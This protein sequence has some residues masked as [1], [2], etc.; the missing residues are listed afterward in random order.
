MT[1]ILG[2]NGFSGVGHDAAAALLVDG[3]VV[4]AV[5]EE[6][7]TR[8]KRAPG[9]PP[10]QAISETL[11]IAGISAAD[12][13]VVTYPWMPHAMGVA[14]ADVEAAIRSWFAE[15]RAST[16]IRFV[17][18]HLAHA[19]SGMAFAPGGIRGRRVGMLVIDGSGEATGGACYTYDGSNDATTLKWRLPQS[20]SLGVYY[21]AASFYLGF[22]WGDEGK[23]MGMAAYG[24][25]LGLQV[26]PLP[27]HRFDQPLPDWV[28]HDKSPREAHSQCRWQFIEEFRRLHG[29]QL[30]FNQRADIALAA[31]NIVGRRIAEYVTE[32]LDD[33]DVLVISGGV[34]L[35][36]AINAQTAAQC[37]AKGVEFVVPPPA[38]DTGV[39][40]GSAVAV[41]STLDGNQN[42]QSVTPITDPFL[43]RMFE[44]DAIMKDLR[45][46]GAV[47]ET[48]SMEALA[49]KLLEG[50]AICGWF[51][52]RS[53]IGP[54]ALGKR[55]I[56]ARTDS[57]SLR[58]RVNLLKGRESWRPLAPSVTTAEFAR[59]F[60]GSTPSAYMLINATITPGAT[61]RLCG[62]VHVD[63]T[64]RPQV[65]DTAGAYHNLLKRVGVLSGTEAV[66]CTSF[67]RAGEPMVYTP[68][69][70]LKSAR[71]MGL[72]LLAGDGWLVRL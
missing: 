32:L 37:H 40:L 5:E 45:N 47:V 56:I 8:V 12:I 51:E 30:S 14:Q 33:I 48:T 13:D 61:R 39:A 16:E 38:S 59:S 34:A 53:E 23:T 36:C 69:D 22:R 18:H 66:I 64:S 24:R 44:P 6:R 29:D 3:V 9:M 25:D 49:T 41:A 10:T 20:S 35:N 31:Q 50:S 28:E 71:A 55:S 43:G 11:H 46:Q 52:G 27:N 7:L 54:R 19:W 72:D 17:E 21:E 42:G 68:A 60:A 70:A 65:V 2:V 26:P 62:V 15:E 4:A 58:D 63:D 67:N 1:I 57:V